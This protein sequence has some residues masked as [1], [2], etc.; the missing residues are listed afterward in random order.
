M[1]KKKSF[2]KSITNITKKMKR[3]N[4]EENKERILKTKE[5]SY[6]EKI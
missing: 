6:K 2:C 4:T 3:G 5:D 1:S